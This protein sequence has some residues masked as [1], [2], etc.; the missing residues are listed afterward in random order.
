MTTANT[1]QNETTAPAVGNTDWLKRGSRIIVCRPLSEKFGNK[2]R[3]GSRGSVLGLRSHTG[4]LTVDILTE[5]G[6]ATG[7]DP[8]HLKTDDRASWGK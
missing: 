8:D 1:A 2:Q 7:V 4:K 6:Y 3:A 5:D